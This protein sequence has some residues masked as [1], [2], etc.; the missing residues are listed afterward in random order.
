MPNVLALILAAGRVDEL[1]LLTLDRPKSA[2][3]SADF[4]G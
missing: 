2:S 4:T 3:P 1:S